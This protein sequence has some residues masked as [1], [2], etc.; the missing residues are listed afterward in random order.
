MFCDP[1]GT[2]GRTQGMQEAELKWVVQPIINASKDFGVIYNGVLLRLFYYLE[3]LDLLNPLNKLHMYGL[4]YVYIPRIN[5]SLK[6]FQSEWNH[7]PISTAHHHSP[8]QLFTGGALSLQVRS[9][10]D[11]FNVYIDDDE[12]RVEVMVSVGDGGRADSLL[13]PFQTYPALLQ[14]FRKC[15]DRTT[16]A[17]IIIVIAGIAVIVTAIAIVIGALTTVRAIT[18]KP[19]H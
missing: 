9:G 8:H 14:H 5:K 16:T 10:D 6:D 4:H 13:A 18:L 12:V 7:H 1:D 19:H 17:I 15:W 2:V 3:Q 11:D